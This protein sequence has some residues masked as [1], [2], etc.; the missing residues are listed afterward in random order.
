M[1]DIWLK[2]IRMLGR[3]VCGAGNSECEGNI[4]GEGNIGAE[5]AVDWEKLLRLAQKHSIAA[6]ILPVVDREKCPEKVYGR[7]VEY[8]GKNLEKSLLFDGERRRVYAAFEE[9]GI[10]YVP[11]KGI[12][13]DGLYPARGMREF[14]DNDILIDAGNAEKAGKIM[15]SLGYE[16][17]LG[18][19]HDACHRD[20][21]FN[22][23]IHKKLFLDDNPVQSYFSDI[24]D[25]CVPVQS[26]SGFELRMTDE[27][28]YIH[29]LTHFKKHFTN[30]GTGLRSFADIWL[31]KNSY[32]QRGIQV[33]PDLLHTLGLDSFE[34]QVLSLAEGLFAHPDTL[35]Y[36]D[37]AYIMESGTY[38]T[39][40]HS[41]ENGIREKGRFRYILSHLFLPL[42]S[43][44]TIYP[45]L[46]RCPWLL[47]FFWCVRLVSR[48]FCK[49]S[50]RRL[51]IMLKIASG[52]NIKAS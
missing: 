43:M 48:L 17:S 12:I 45:V 4:G 14:A 20:P 10:R 7:W 25:R 42:S 44:R 29:V 30:G 33:S 37:L 23:E 6:T 50:R 47:P 28:F 39:L 15:T 38:G 26:G 36:D 51:K 21:V 18:D 31:L 46:C 9:A 19:V 49:D 5:D 8:A 16:V 35:S 40:K 2:L 32:V 27:D 11:L 13:L 52:K 34:Q 41:C 24:M 3:S 22:F 1:P